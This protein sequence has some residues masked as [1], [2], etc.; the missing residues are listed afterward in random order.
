MAFL[1]LMIKKVWRDKFLLKFM[2]G[3]KRRLTMKKR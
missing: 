2:D 3:K 1:A